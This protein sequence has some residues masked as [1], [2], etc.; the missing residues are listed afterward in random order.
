MKLIYYSIKTS[1]F[2]AI[3]FILL[4]FG[5]YH[6]QENTK[7]PELRRAF[8]KI[9]GD[10]KKAEPVY[11]AFKLSAVD[12][13]VAKA[14]IGTLESI[15]AAEQG[16]PFSKLSWFNKGKKKIEEAI[17]SSPDNAEIHFLRLSVQQKAPG[18]LF[19]YSDINKD[20]KIVINHIDHFDKLN[21][22]K[23]VVDFLLENCELTSEEKSKIKQ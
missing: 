15:L 12:N 14:Y 6:F 23:E 18:F 7:L 9:E 16:N 21:I 5:G 8:F 17:K 19:Y 13:D 2:V 10:S 11:I 22:K 20:K 1:L 3:G 4:S